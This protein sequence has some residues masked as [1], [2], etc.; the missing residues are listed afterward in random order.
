[1]KC[2]YSANHLL[3]IQLRNSFDNI[4]GL[5]LATGGLVRLRLCHGEL[6]L[7]FFLQNPPLVEV[8]NLESS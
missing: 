7:L 8:V 5:L 4:K 3:T 1:M 6:V 2:T